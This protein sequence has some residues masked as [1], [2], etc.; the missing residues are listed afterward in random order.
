MPPQRHL[1]FEGILGGSLQVEINR[2]TRSFP[3][4]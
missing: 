4:T 2:R 3:A 1:I